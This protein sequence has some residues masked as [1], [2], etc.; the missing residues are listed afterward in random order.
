MID[1]SFVI[2]FRP[3]NIDYKLQ[4]NISK[5]IFDFKNAFCVCVCVEERKREKLRSSIV[6]H[7]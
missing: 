5:F 4:A 7:Y 2:S 6:C 3:D 1:I